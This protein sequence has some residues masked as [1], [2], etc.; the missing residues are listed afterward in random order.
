MNVHH[1]NFFM[2]GV[3]D[4][5]VTT[6]NKGYSTTGNTKVFHRYLP[7]EVGELLIYYLWL[8]QPICRKLEM[9]LP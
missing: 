8:V 5:T 1:R 3:M 9:F 7:K 2:E 6:H 4:S